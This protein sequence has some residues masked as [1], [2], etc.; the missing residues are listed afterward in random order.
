MTSLS[1]LDLSRNYYNSSSDLHFV[2]SGNLFHLDLSF[3]SLNHEADWISDFLRDKCH[4]KS[5]NLEGNHFHGDISGAFK[6]VSGCWSKNLKSLSLGFNEFC[7]HLPEELGE[8]KQLKELVVS[9]NQ[10]SGEIPVSLGQLSNLE[11]IYIYNNTFEGTLTEAHFA[12]LSKLELL[13]VGSNYMLKLSVGYDWVPPFQLKYLYLRSAKIGGQQFPDWLQTQKALTVLDLSNCSITGV[14][15]KWLHS[16][17][18][19]TEL[20]LSNNHIEGPIPELASNLIRLYLSDNMINGSIHDSLCQ[21][22]ELYE[23]DLSRNQL[24]GNLP[25]CWGN[26]PSLSVAILS[27]NQFSGPIPNSIGGAYNL[28]WLQLDDNSFTGQLPTTLSS[29]TSLYFLDAGD[30]KLSG[31]LPQWNIGHYPLG[32]TVLR[33]RNNE[34]HG[35]IPSAYCQLSKLKIMDLA[36]NNLTG[37]ISRCFGNFAGMVKGAGE[38][39]FNRSVKFFDTNTFFSTDVSLSEVMKGVMME[40][41]TTSMYVVNLDLSSNHL[42]GDIPPELTN[43]SGLIGLNLSNN[44]LGGKIPSK[45]GDMKSLESLDLS[46]NNLSE[47][48][49]ESLSKLNSLSHLNLSN[50]DLFGQIPT[51]PQLQTL[52]NPSIYEGNRGLC[53]DPLLKKCRINDETPPNVE[54][55][56]GDDDDGDRTDKIYLYAFIISGFATGFWGYFGVLVF[57]RSWRLAL[58]WH[59]DAVIG[60]MLGWY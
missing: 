23:L 24:S 42:V 40:Y 51:G 22:K 32:L 26:F 59:M 44:H 57:K 39:I 37:N 36:E 43:L 46:G 8:L 6:N 53:G 28:G 25:N 52:N 12:N 55:D 41:T 35:A 20:Y 4:L 17:M 29:C 30:N 3:N 33:L 15:P 13:S 54:N 18:N 45:I 60:R 7:G 10:L 48:I 58:F 31:K 49:P 1:Y 9:Y 5:L 2:T 14:L 21:M 56:T 16:L 27:S 34:F 50:N 19:L 38:F 47:T 11:R